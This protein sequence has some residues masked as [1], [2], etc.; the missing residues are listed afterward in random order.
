MEEFHDEVQKEKK[1]TVA[2]N[3]SEAKTILAKVF[4]DQ[5]TAKTAQIV[6]NYNKTEIPSTNSF[7]NKKIPKFFKCKLNKI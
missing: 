4:A 1:C 7:L 6:T 5:T 2:L 3:I